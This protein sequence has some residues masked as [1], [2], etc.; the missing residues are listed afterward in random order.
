MHLPQCAVH[1]QISGIGAL[2]SAPL[3][4]AEW[5]HGETDRVVASVSEGVGSTREPDGMRG[6]AG[7]AVKSRT[8]TPTV[9][10]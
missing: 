1:V 7:E 4:L 5:R 8:S 10:T 3:D 6:E 2:E 9:I